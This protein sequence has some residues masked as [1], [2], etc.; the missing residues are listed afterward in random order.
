M[1]VLS[2]AIHRSITASNF[3][4]F[5]TTYPSIAFAKTQSPARDTA[6]CVL[7]QVG[8]AQSTTFGP[9]SLEEIPFWLATWWN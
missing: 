8:I 6:V 9:F 4:A 1:F 5:V 7:P 2:G 3:A